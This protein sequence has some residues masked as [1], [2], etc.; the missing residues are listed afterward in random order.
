MIPKRLSL[1]V[2]MAKN[3]VIG[4]NNSIPWHLPAELNLFKSI[5]MGHHIIMG[6]R[7]YES[8]NRLLP[9]RSTIIVTRNINYSVPGALVVH[10]LDE[11]LSAAAT[12]S[13][14]LVIGG[15]ELF[16][17]ALPI[18]NRIYLTII[19]TEVLGDTYMPEFEI[20]KWQLVEKKEFKADANNA[21]DF[22]FSIYDKK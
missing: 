18:A 12:D 14:V 1:I 11:A 4:A 8:I 21:Y 2:A 19:Q 16:R 7:T 10:S 5:T 13:E 22:I 3:R 15:A 6:R 17:I 9:G 20:K